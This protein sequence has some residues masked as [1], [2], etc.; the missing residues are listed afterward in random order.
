M[1]S[2]K[3]LPTILI[4]GIFL[5]AVVF[6]GVK[7]ASRFTKTDFAMDTYISI[8]AN[9]LHA[10]KAGQQALDRIYSIEKNMSA[11]L[12]TS[13]LA[14]GVLHEDTLQVV[15]RGLYYSELSNGLYDITIKPL[16]DLWDITGDNPTVPAEEDIQRVIQ[17]IGYEKLTI[18]GNKLNM[19][20][21]LGSIAKGYAADEAARILKEQDIKDAVI[22]LGGD[23]FAVGEKTVGIKNPKE[24]G[25]N[26]ILAAVK[27]KDCAVVTS[28][29][30][31][32]NFT[33]DGKTYH[34][35]LN[36]KTGYPQNSGLI[37]A[38]VIADSAMDA[39]ALATIVFMLGEDGIAFAEQQGVKAITV[40]ESGRISTTNDVQLEL[41]NDNFYLAED[42]F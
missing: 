26:A 33:V 27:V 14:T 35:I 25:D 5:A 9:G 15:K 18:D 24:T 21:D 29:S 10:K 19:P 11:H 28:G 34:H 1:K 12:S 39:D 40:H 7:S 3:T 31:E 41:L 20:V 22:D 38:T 6:A 30:Y 8:S 2:F 37:S 13:D 32:R 17:Q 4:L 16:L 23:V 42:T 36:P